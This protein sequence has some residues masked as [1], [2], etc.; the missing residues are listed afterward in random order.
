MLHQATTSVF[1]KMAIQG[2][3]YIVVCV[4]LCAW[5]CVVCLLVVCLL[6]VVCLLVVCLLGVV[7][8]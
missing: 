3:T 5:H 8:T 4:V 7:F 2:V 6:C 1:G